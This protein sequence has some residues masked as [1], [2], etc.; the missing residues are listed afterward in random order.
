MAFLPVSLGTNHL[1][2]HAWCFFR[3]LIGIYKV[4]YYFK[5]ETK[6]RWR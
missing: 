4:R 6:A 2:Y 1:R 3:F 5:V